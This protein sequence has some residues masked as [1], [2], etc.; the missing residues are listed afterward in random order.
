MW[1]KLKKWWRLLAAKAWQ[2]LPE[3]DRPLAAAAAKPEATNITWTNQT[4]HPPSIT[5]VQES[6]ARTGEGP[7]PRELCTWCKE[8]IL[9]GERHPL[10]HTC[11]VECAVRIT[12][13]SV[14]HIEQRCDCFVEGSTEADPE[15]LSARDA[16]A[17]AYRLI[18]ERHRGPSN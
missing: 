11:H 12:S 14:A 13:G 6:H 15:G 4:Y 5:M 3:E 9:V 1:K 10:I 2:P 17:M 8:P 18:R 7:D 16:A